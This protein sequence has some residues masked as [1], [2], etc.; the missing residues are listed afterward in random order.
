MLVTPNVFSSLIHY[1]L[2]MEAIR[3][4]ETS[5]LTSNTGSHLRSRVTSS[6]VVPFVVLSVPSCRPLFTCGRPDS[7]H[8]QLLQ[9]YLARADSSC[10]CQSVKFASWSIYEGSMSVRLKR[11]RTITFLQQKPSPNWHV[12]IR[13]AVYYTVTC[14]RLTDRICGLVVRLPGC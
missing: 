4:C 3:F 1:T 12:Q 8:A 14:Q 10:G 6:I 7:A 11:A 5:V 9:L 2:M 13:L